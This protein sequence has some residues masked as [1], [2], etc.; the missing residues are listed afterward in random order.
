M[1][2]NCEPGECYCVDDSG[3]FNVCGCLQRERCKDGCGACLNCDG[4]YCGE[5]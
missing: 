1:A 2:C 3:A 5:G 4:C